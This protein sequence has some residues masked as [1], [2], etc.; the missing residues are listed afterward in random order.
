MFLLATI[1]R[2]RVEVG[3]QQFEKG[4]AWDLTHGFNRTLHVSYFQ[5]GPESFTSL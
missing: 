2:E 5:C 1:V 4:L 3:R